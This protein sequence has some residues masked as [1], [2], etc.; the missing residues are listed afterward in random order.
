MAGVSTPRL[1]AAVSNAGALGAIAVGAATVETARAMIQETRAATS[2]PFQVNVFCHRPAHR[3]AA[4]EGAW[5]RHLAP[6]FAEF[7][8]SPPIALQEIYRS[9]CED[10]G[11]LELLLSERPSVVSFHFG[12]PSRTRI[13]AL[14]A[15]GIT[16]LATATSEREA[17]AVVAAGIDA[18]VAQGVEAGGHRGVFDPE[19]ED[20][21]LDTLALVRRLAGRLSVPVVAAGGMM[22]GEDIA[23]ALA[24][25]AEA[26]QLGTAFVPCPESAADAAYRAMLASERARNTALT[27]AISGRPARGIVNRF[28]EEIDVPG[29]PA[30]AD[31]P[32]AYDAGKAL[33]AAATRAGSA[34][35]APLWAGQGARWSRVMPAQ[36]L[37]EKLVEELDAAR[38]GT[39]RLRP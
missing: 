29:R 19:A 14:R 12:L 1:A 39:S 21:G 33:N 36:T 2:A 26:A 13:E 16:L 7:G 8:V 3:D 23:A 37:V 32:V 31:Y 15:A 28:H 27:A 38:E 4:R 18:V 24:A 5:L 17:D 25:G 35:F 34:E 22:R 6:F 10:D 20:E 30:A 11:M 9:F